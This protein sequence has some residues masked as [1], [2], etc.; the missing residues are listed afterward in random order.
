V[1]DYVTPLIQKY[2]KSGVLVDTNLLILFFVGSFQRA[3]IT[4]FKLTCTFTEDDYDLLCQFL[5]KF[6][7]VITTPNVLTEVSNLAGQ[8]GSHLKPDF[9]SV[10]AQG[11]KVLEEFHQPSAEIAATPAFIKFGLTDAV[12]ANLAEGKY[13]VITEDHR[14]TGY[15]QS[16]NI[17]VLNFNHLRGAM[18][19][20]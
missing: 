5:G 17:D 7:K 3:Q 8:L 13:L 6:E 9:F 2:R 4:Q 16:R 11:I 1:N 18:Y 19:L 14:V 10:F 20:S 12:I 15:L